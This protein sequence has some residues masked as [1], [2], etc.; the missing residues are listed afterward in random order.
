MINVEKTVELSAEINGM[1]DDVKGQDVTDLRCDIEI[2]DSSDLYARNA[3]ASSSPEKEG[4]IL[5]SIV[6]V[7][8]NDSE[9]TIYQEVLDS[10]DELSRSVELVEQMYPGVITQIQLDSLDGT[11]S[12]GAPHE[13]LP[14]E[15]DDD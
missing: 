14:W 9:I 11:S 5:L 6:A 12:E 7:M 15:I 1:S 8:T 10:Q 2:S 4:S 3:I 13:S